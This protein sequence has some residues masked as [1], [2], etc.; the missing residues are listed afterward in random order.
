[1]HACRATQFS[2][3]HS[4]LLSSISKG[5]AH[6]SYLGILPPLR[7]ITFSHLSGKDSARTNKPPPPTAAKPGDL[8]WVSTC[9][10]LCTNWPRVS[11]SL[12][13]A[14]SLS[15]KRLMCAIRVSCMYTSLHFLTSHLVTSE[16]SPP[17]QLRTGR[18]PDVW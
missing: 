18:K 16:P 10:I 11:Y 6:A 9:C 8:R 3:C 12:L 13:Q 7:L 4:V 14:K 15:S 1:M 17:T 2:F 5:S